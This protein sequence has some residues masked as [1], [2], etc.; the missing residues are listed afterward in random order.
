MPSLVD[1]PIALRHRTDT[2]I[3]HLKLPMPLTATD[4]ERLHQFLLTL[5]Q[6]EPPPDA[7]EIP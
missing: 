5:V 6:E 4:V 3:A 1:Y 2:I 7:K